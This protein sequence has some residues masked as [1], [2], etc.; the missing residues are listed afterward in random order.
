MKRSLTL[1]H[2][3]EFVA[4]DVRGNASRVVTGVAP[5]NTAQAEDITWLGQ[6][7]YMDQL[8]SSQAGAVLLDRQIGPTP[9]DAVLCDD[10]EHAVAVV[11]D[12]FAPPLPAPDVGIH[13]SAS[14]APSATIGRDVA[15]GPGVVVAHNASVGD[16]SV[17]H[18]GVFVGSE[19]HLGTDCRLWNNVVVRERCRLGDRVVIHPNS[20]IGADGFAYYLRNRHHH[21]VPHIGGVTIGD[22]VEIGAC[23]CVDRSKAGETVIGRDVKIDNLVQVAHN[24][25]VGDGCLLCAQVGVAGSARLGDY[26]VLGGQA[27]IRDNV[28]VKDGVMVGAMAGVAHDVPAG[29]K[30]V[31]MPAVDARQFARQSAALHKLPDLLTQV[32]SLTKRVKEL[33]AAADHKPDD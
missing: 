21:K 26:V 20:V 3:A 31:G 19:S 7:R 32:R 17:L 15:V 22:D 24:V 5:V 12:R 28:V 13:P 29:A 8:Q 30:I 23:S 33:E 27:G 18:S 4:G 2:I 6:P 9:M 25:A 11:L 14:I 16:R 1:A 10:L